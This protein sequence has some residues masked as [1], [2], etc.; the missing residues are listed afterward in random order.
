MRKVNSWRFNGSAQF[1]GEIALV[2][3]VIWYTVGHGHEYPSSFIIFGRL[4][5]RL[6]TFTYIF[7][8]LLTYSMEHSPSREANRFSARQEIP[9]ILRNRQVRYSVHKCPP[10]VPVLLQF[11]P[12]H[13]TASHF[14]KILNIILPRF[15]FH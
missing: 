6:I 4:H 2:V 7:I 1:L 11:N 13:A 8:Y 10:Y 15:M 9:R 14:L 5:F 12:V 3:R